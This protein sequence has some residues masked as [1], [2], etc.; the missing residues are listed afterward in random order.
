MKTINNLWIAVLATIMLLI[1]SCSKEEMAIDKTYYS[2]ILVEVVSLPGTP[3][4]EVYYQGQL[5][6]DLPLLQPGTNVEIGTN[7]KLAVYVKGTDQL[8][9]DTTVNLIKDELNL[10]RVA[11]NEELG[12]SGW[13]NS[14]SVHEDSLSVQFLNN[15]S[16]YYKAYP[17][18][19][20]CIFYYD[21]NMGTIEDFQ[22]SITDFQ[23]IKLSPT[24]ILLPYYYGDK[25][26]AIGNFFVGKL[27]DKATG[28]FIM[29]PS[30]NDWFLL[31]PEYGG[32]NC[33][34]NLYDDGSGDVIVNSIIL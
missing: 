6:G 10:Y 15:L 9:A 30:G 27:K 3:E 16:D 25:A 11:Y 23:K 34:Y 17:A 24:A 8:V 29:M 4:L 20:L 28:Q 26:D 5:I 2:K 1:V 22:M 14:K 7:S 19:D 13:V 21:F 33:I 32:Q 18:Y 12:I 31:P